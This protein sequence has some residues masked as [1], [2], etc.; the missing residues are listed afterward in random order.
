MS[1]LD[2]ENK[3]NEN[4]IV[5]GP[6]MVMYILINTDLEMDKGKI[7]SQTA[8]VA[9]VITE[10]IIRSVYET[11]PVPD[12]YFRYYKWKNGGP[13]GTKIVL[14]ATESQLLEL[15]KMDESRYI[16]DNGPTT[17]V[18]SGSLTCVGFF[19]TDKLTDTFKD[20]KL[21]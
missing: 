13:I 10:E 7:A 1:T 6:K 16:I 11:R 4:K 5:S 15:I 2:S 3:Q 20:Y 9:Q 12:Y 19:P 8:H 18:K 17:Q 21:L 14:K